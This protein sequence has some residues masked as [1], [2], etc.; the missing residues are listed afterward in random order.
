MLV[1]HAQLLLQLNGV[2]LEETNK[3][4]TSHSLQPLTCIPDGPPQLYFQA[5]PGCV[6]F[7]SHSL[8]LSFRLG[9]SAST[10]PWSPSRLRRNHQFSGLHDAPANAASTSS[11]LLSPGRF[12]LRCLPTASRLQKSSSLQLRFEIGRILQPR[13]QRIHYLLWVHMTC[14][15]ELCIL[16]N[17]KYRA[18]F[19]CRCHTDFLWRY[20]FLLLCFVF[21]FFAFSESAI[22]CSIV[23]R[24]A[25]A[26]REILVFLFS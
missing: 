6:Y 13:S 3:C 14:R 2:A 25:N 1:S 5:L 10:P 24:Y 7:I 21:V 9:A 26:D 12:A 19:G 11:T 17:L 8:K 16:K 20:V 18:F 22:L 15:V 23:L 4:C